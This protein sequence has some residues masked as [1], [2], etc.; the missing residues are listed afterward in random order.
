[1][2]CEV[3]GHVCPGNTKTCRVCGWRFAPAARTK[4]PCPVCF[5]EM[6]GKDAC[7]A[8]GFRRGDAASPAELRTA[9]AGRQRDMRQTSV[10]VERSAEQ[11]KPRA[12][13]DAKPSPDEEAERQERENRERIAAARRAREEAER[14]AREAAARKILEEAGR[15]AR[16]EAGR[17][18]REAAAR[19]ARRRRFA[20]ASLSLAALFAAIWFDFTGVPFAGA[21]L[22]PALLALSAAM[23]FMSL[24]W[25]EETEATS[26]WTV[27]PLLGVLLIGAVWAV[28][29][30]PALSA[31]RN[32]FAKVFCF[33]ALALSALSAV[34]YPLMDDM[35]E[36]FS[37][38]YACAQVALLALCTVLCGAL[39]L[40][41]RANTDAGMLLA[42][43]DAAEFIDSVFTAVW[44]LHFASRCFAP[45]DRWPCFGRQILFA[46]ALALAGAAVSVGALGLSGGLR[47]YGT[48]VQSAAA[49]AVRL[50]FG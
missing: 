31:F 13:E 1:M 48:A 43:P 16:E 7:P 42:A 21:F 5:A 37:P 44:L 24:L 29:A 36:D 49:G 23:M 26:D 46:A 35:V 28:S 41:L 50:L 22:K 32:D 47:L 2:Q 40:Q 17:K 11:Q 4:E 39:L 20:G 25:V 38:I 27:L 8:C 45:A 14:K 30:I 10:R 18:A 6:A 19:K 3:C 15:K 33:A 12:A 34:L 9:F